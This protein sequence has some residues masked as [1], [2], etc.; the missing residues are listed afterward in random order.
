MKERCIGLAFSPKGE[1]RA[2]AAPLLPA[3][4]RLIPGGPPR[5][6][7]SPALARGKLHYTV[8][9][10]HPATNERAP[11]IPADAPS[12]AGKSG[13]SL[14]PRADYW[15]RNPHRN[16]FSFKLPFP[17]MGARGARL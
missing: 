16:C 15:F 7:A 11:V 5:L 2:A 12:A 9:R 8:P 4:R 17:L 13:P 3:Y 14:P 1:R 10:G 6:V